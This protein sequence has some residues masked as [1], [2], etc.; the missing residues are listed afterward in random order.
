LRGWDLGFGIWDLGF[1][2]WEDV[3]FGGMGFGVY[4]VRVVMLRHVRCVV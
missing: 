4:G 3:G 1:G 2:I